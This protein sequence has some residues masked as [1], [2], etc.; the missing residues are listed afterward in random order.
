MD[1]DIHSFANTLIETSRASWK[2][3]LKE[4]STEHRDKSTL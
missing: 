4:P 1:I 3:L 2:S